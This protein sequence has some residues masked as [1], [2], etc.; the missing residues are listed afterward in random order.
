MHMSTLR[1]T[2]IYAAG[3]VALTIA[4]SVPASAQRFGAPPEIVVAESRWGNGVVSGPTRRGRTGWQVRMPRG[5]WI[6]CVRSCSETL[7]RA[8][9]DFWES[10][11]P[12]AVDTGPGYFRWDFNF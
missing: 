6:D 1:A 9:V 11:G 7:R 12:R 4:V 8:T 3:I 10:N 5:T 2:S